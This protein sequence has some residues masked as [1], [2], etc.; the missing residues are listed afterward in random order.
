[1]F[2]KFEHVRVSEITCV[3]EP[4]SDTR[5]AD[6]S[7]SLTKLFMNAITKKLRGI[8]FGSINGAAV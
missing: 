4:L 7:W 8:Q 3:I 6:T 1:M 5:V 2:R